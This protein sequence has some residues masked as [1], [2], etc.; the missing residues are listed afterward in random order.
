M[1]IG[2]SEIYLELN[3]ILNKFNVSVHNQ[4]EG[5]FYKALGGFYKWHFFYFSYNDFINLILS[6]IFSLLIPIIIYGNFLDAKIININGFYRW[7][8]LLFFSPA[9]ICFILALDHGRNISLVAT[10]LI[11]YFSI[12]NIN[13]AKIKLLEQQIYTNINKL[14]LLILFIFFYLFL[15]K[16]DQ[17]AGFAFQ[18]KETTIFKSSLFAEFIKLVK[19]IYSY[20]LYFI[21]LPEIK[22]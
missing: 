16:L 10:H 14:T 19:L 15:W 6:L 3:N 11:I 18:G 17:S 21:E 8:Y 20:D 12:L 5:G 22:L 4:L 7:G 9:I 13:E 2:N 1:F